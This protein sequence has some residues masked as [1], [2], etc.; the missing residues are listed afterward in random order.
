[1]DRYQ[2]VKL[3]EWAGTLRTRKRLQKVVYLLQCAGCPLEAEFTLHHYGPYS[4][5]VA[6]LADELVQAGL[7]M[8]TEGVNPAGR[9]FSYALGERAEKLLGLAADE[10][11]VPDYHEEFERHRPLAEQLLREGDL[12]KLEYAS[13]IA[14]FYDLQDDWDVALSK[15]A[16]FKN[17]KQNSPQMQEALSLAK[18]IVD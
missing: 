6:R 13:T 2:M 1:M 3:V 11:G 7:L 8:E 12:R 16:K 4:F 10:A 5:E 14:Y 15:A 9:E 18:S 17:Q